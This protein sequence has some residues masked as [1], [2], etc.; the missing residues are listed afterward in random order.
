[1]Y[2]NFERRLNQFIIDRSWDQYHTV[3]NLIMAHVCEVAE[4]LELFTVGDYKSDRVELKKEVGD[5]FITLFCL[6]R[7]AEIDISKHLSKDP[8]KT[9]SDKFGELS[10]QFL[11]QLLSVKAAF[12]QEAFLWIKDEEALNYVDEVPI[13]LFSLPFEITLAL[14]HLLGFDPLE[15]MN[16]K[17]DYTAQKY[18]L[19]FAGSDTILKEMNKKKS[20]KRGK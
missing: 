13:S 6:Y 15:T 17:L 1:M 12:L 19:E 8:I 18:S 14:A 20:I 5:C 16:E 7:K 4:L 3:R 9:L 10:P 2:K 11:A